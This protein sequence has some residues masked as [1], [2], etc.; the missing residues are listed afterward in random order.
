MT[1][2][3]QI[4]LKRVQTLFQ[5]AKEVINR[6]PEQAQRYVEIAR[7]IAMRARLRLPKEYRRL[8][9]RKCKNFI[10]PGVNCRVRIQQRREPHIVV[11]CYNCG[12]YSRIPLKG[13]EKQC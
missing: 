9:C 6:D 2:T 13:R 1:S 3:K 7:R 8:V 11:T 4:A 12:G 10:L 5:L